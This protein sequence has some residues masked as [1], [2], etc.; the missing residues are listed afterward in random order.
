MTSRPRG[1]WRLA[2]TPKWVGALLL[3]LA[4]AAAFA[5][6]GQWQLERSFRQVGTADPNPSAQVAVPIDDIVTAGQPLTARADGA[7]VK[8][9]IM[10]DT[11]K[12][13]IVAN[14]QQD[15]VAGYWLIANSRTAV[16]NSLTVA[17]GFTDQ[18]SDAEQERIRL[19]QAVQAQAFISHTGTFLATEAPQRLDPE[20]EYILQ[21]LSLA[22]LVNLYSPERPLIS[23]P[24]FV[25]LED[26][27][28]ALDPID[29]GA[30]AASLEINYLNIFY[31]LE[32]ALF[33]GFAVFLWWRLVKDAVIAERLN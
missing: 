3:S 28:V 24:G 10:I 30:K 16:G 2:L 21:S 11:Q 7:R 15:E 4:V 23:Y 26:R 25:V 12:V 20:H 6:L 13:Y 1:F 33:A 17:L 31:A 9:E 27:I 19:M 8:F 14:R 29:I 5:L 32:W 22:Q 18:L